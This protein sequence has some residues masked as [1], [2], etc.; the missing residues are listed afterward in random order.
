MVGSGAS[1]SGTLRSGVVAIGVVAAVA[2]AVTIGATSVVGQRSTGPF[3]GLPCPGPPTS[4]VSADGTGVADDAC[5]GCELVASLACGA[6]TT[7]GSPVGSVGCAWVDSGQASVSEGVAA[8]GVES[9]VAGWMTEV[10][11]APARATVSSPLDAGGVASGHAGWIGSARIAEAGAA[12]RGRDRRGDRRRCGDVA[13]RCWRVVAVRR[14]RRD[15][16]ERGEQ[17]VRDHLERNRAVRS[18]AAAQRLGDVGGRM[19]IVRSFR[20]GDRIGCGVGAR[21]GRSVGGRTVHAVLRLRARRVGCVALALGSPPVL[22]V[23]TGLRSLVPFVHVWPVHLLEGARAGTRP[24]CR[25]VR[26]HRR[27]RH[28]WRGRSGCACCGQEGGR[29]HMCSSRSWTRWT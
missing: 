7:V 29:G 28:W 4:G 6:S 16:C 2:R 21:P 5:N 22:I 27:R 3:E 8:T 11:V 15:A 19:R 18:V 20:G 13:G 26:R 25:L 10:D 23:E 9:D 17:R 12:Q 24:R 1:R 14:T